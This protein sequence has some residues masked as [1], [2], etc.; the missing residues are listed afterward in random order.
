MRRANILTSVCL[1][2]FTGFYAV[3]IAR[4]P[5]RDLPHTLGAAFVPWVLAGILFFLSSLLLIENLKDKNVPQDQRTKI[6]LKELAGIIGLIALIV[7]YIILLKYLGFIIASIGFMAALIFL[8]GSR[9]PLEIAFFSTAT[10]MAVYLLFQKFFEVQL[11][12]GALF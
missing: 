1:I 9:K 3:L 8:S 6:D 2:V 10:T 4:L 5:N 12:T 11:P 7:A